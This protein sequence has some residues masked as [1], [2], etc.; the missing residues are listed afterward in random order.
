MALRREL[1]P[2]S[3]VLFTVGAMI[4]SGIFVTPHDVAAGVPSGALTL[5]L[6]AA[7]GVLSLLGAL[8]FTE[9]GAAIPEAGGM[10]PYFRRAFGPLAAFVFGW[11]M[12]AV[13]VP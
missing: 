2:V 7:A 5:G 12:L 6:W 4:G 1:G 10:Y 11:A 9:L 3:A 8:S 13:L